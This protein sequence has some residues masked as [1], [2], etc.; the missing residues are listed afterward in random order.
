MKQISVELRSREME[1]LLIHKVPVWH[2][3]FQQLIILKPIQKVFG[4]FGN[5]FS[6]SISIQI[7][8]K[9]LC[10]TQQGKRRHLKQTSVSEAERYGMHSAFGR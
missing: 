6:K 10:F 7:K 9:L 5:Y 3:Y 4:A 2:V 1:L 8:R